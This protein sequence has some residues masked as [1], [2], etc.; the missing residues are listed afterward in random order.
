MSTYSK[1]DET[2]ITIKR[3]DGEVTFDPLCKSD[4]SWLNIK[5]NGIMDVSFSISIQSNNYLD[6]L[7]FIKVKLDD[8]I[9]EERRKM[10]KEGDE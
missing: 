4:G 1:I 2:K 8:I 10:K 6:A 5:R 9:E 3:D 7:K